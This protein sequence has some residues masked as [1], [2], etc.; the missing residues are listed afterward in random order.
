MCL[1]PLKYTVGQIDPQRFST[2]CLQ[3]FNSSEDDYSETL[4]IENFSQKSTIH[5]YPNKYRFLRIYYRTYF[6][7]NIYRLRSM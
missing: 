4:I 5:I 1:K 2:C 3:S 7:H 6:Y